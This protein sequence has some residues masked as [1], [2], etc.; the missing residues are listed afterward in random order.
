MLLAPGNV[1][2]SLILPLPL[3]VKPDGPPL[4]VAVNVTAVNV[5]GKVSLTTAPVA[6]LG[7]GLLTVIV[8]V[9]LVPALAALF[10]SVI[11]TLTSACATSV[12]VSVAVLFAA[13][14][15]VT[16]AGTETVAVSD[17]QPLADGLIVP[18]AL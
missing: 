9:S 18:V 12:S 16:P 3:V 14:G 4:W 2:V 1:T 13:F 5:L 11:V 8:Y 10:S 15:S 6:V 17:I 7:P